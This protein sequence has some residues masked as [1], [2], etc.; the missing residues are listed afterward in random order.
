MIHAVWLGCVPEQAGPHLAA[1]LVGFTPG[2]K[3]RVVFEAEERCAGC[4]V[5]ICVCKYMQAGG[6][7]LASRL[8]R[9]AD[10]VGLGRVLTARCAQCK[11]ASALLGLKCEGCLG[12]ASSG[13]LS[14]VCLA[15]MSWA[16]LPA[17]CQVY[18]PC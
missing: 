10:A 5:L 9:V 3:V 2:H 17:A 14:N 1:S 6:G 11:L 4:A 16:C 18:E 13:L 12:T 8:G 7:K 15:R